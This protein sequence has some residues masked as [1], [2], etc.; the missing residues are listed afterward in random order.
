MARNSGLNDR[1]GNKAGCG[2]TACARDNEVTNKQG[3]ANPGPP[4]S[5]P[6]LRPEL[7]PIEEGERMG[8]AV[9]KAVVHGEGVDQ[10]ARHH[11]I[12]DNPG[13]HHHLR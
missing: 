10:T 7:G 9:G 5:V 12:G 6:M 3:T 11:R 1:I 8:A 4:P 13:G 2:E